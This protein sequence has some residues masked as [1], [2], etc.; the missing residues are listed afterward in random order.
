MNRPCRRSAARMSCFCLRPRRAM[1][2]RRWRDFSAQPDRRA[3]CACQPSG[4]EW[5]QVLVPLA[6][7]A[8]LTLETASTPARATR[9]CA[10]VQILTTPR[11]LF[12]CRRSALKAESLSHVVLAWPSCENRRR[13]PRSCR[14]LTRTRSGR[15]AVRPPGTSPTVTRGGE[16]WPVPSRL[17]PK[18][19]A[20]CC[21]GTSLQRGTR[22]PRRLEC[23]RNPGSSWCCDLDCD[24]ASAS[25]C[26][27][28]SGADETTVVHGRCR[29]RS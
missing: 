27:R 14:T 8:S 20:A 29:P 4:I 13:S 25:R 18:P 11:L 23:P 10:R 28:T 7:A 21:C 9:V 24:A 26:E 1:R 2:F 16:S 22:V 17:K 12:S 5:A 3:G 15:S 19:R 6:R